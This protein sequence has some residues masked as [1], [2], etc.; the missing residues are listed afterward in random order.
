MSCYLSQTTLITLITGCLPGRS[1]L[2]NLLMYLEAV[3][4]HVDKG[5]PVDAVY[6]DFAK[7]FDKVPNCRL[8]SKLNLKAHGIIGKVLQSSGMD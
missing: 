7:A 6:L 1:C 8:L 3:T 5:E 2:T 4:S